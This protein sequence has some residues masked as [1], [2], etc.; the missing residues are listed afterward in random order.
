MNLQG[1]FSIILTMTGGPQE[2]GRKES[3]QER[4]DVLLASISGLEPGY[5]NKL[6]EGGTLSETD[7]KENARGRLS[8]LNMYFGGMLK[9]L[10]EEEAVEALQTLSKAEIYEGIPDFEDYIKGEIATMP[11]LKNLVDKAFPESE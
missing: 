6:E 2:G 9:I 4:K 1:Y 7:L 5:A 8:A 3:L 11:R 10:T